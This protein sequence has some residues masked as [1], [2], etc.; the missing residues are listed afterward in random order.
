[1]ILP[2][3]ALFLDANVACLL[4]GFTIASPSFSFSGGQDCEQYPQFPR[5]A[6]YSWSSLTL[7]GHQNLPVFKSGAHLS[8]IIPSTLDYSQLG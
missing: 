3:Q 2:F 8:Y 6:T 5:P 1:M 4:N 7:V